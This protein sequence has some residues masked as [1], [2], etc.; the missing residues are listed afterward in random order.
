MNVDRNYTT[1]GEKVVAVVGLLFGALIV[2]AL[3]MI[4]ASTILNLT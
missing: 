3:V 2:V 4:S 1:L